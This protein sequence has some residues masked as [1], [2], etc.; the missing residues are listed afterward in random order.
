MMSNDVL[1]ICNQFWFS[2]KGASYPCFTLAQCFLLENESLA[3]LLSGHHRHRPKKTVLT[4]LIVVMFKIPL[5]HTK[6]SVT[7]RWSILVCRHGLCCHWKSRS[8]FGRSVI[9]RIVKF[10]RWRVSKAFLVH[11]LICSVVMWKAWKTDTTIE[12]LVQN[13][14]WLREIVPYFYSLLL[15]AVT[16]VFFGCWV[17]FCWW[18]SV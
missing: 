7:C 18:V 11:L 6:P 3:V 17:V 16:L 5:S 14:S 10:F 8:W 15:S 4:G 12:F 13:N 9:V 1:D 2:G